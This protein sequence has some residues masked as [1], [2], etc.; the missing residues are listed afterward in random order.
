MIAAS[1]KRTFD[2]AL[3]FS[4]RLFRSIYFDLVWAE[5]NFTGDLSLIPSF[6]LSRLNSPLATLVVFGILWSFFSFLIERREK[7]RE[8]SIFHSLAQ[9]F[10][11]SHICVPSLRRNCDYEYS[12]NYQVHYNRLLL[13]HGHGFL[14]SST[15]STSP[16]WPSSFLPKKARHRSLWLP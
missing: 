6:A 1:R 16:G 4:T 3:L 10:L 7:G 2:T 11:A 14:L 13:Q 8:W 12:Y 15:R 5:L 9:S